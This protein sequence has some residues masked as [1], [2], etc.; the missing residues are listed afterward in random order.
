MNK[1]PLVSI[2]IT[3]YNRS[4]WLQRAIESALAQDYSEFEVIISDNCSTDNSD[5]VIRRYTNDS[6]IKYSRNDTNIGMNANFQKALNILANGEY[7]VFLCSDDYFINNS[8]VSQAA[9]M[10]FSNPGVSIVWGRNVGVF[11]DN[12]LKSH[13]LMPN[14]N[15]AIH[16]K[17][18]DIILDFM[19][20]PFWL[21]YGAYMTK[22]KLINNF[23][24]IV[25]DIP[26]NLELLLEGDAMFIEKDSYVYR[27][28][29]NNAAM[30][31]SF[32][33]IILQ[34]R[35]ILQVLDTAEMKFPTKEKSLVNSK[36]TVIIETAKSLLTL[37]AYRNIGGYRKVYSY[38]EKE[39]PHLV[40]QLPTKKR[41]I[42]LK[43]FVIQIILSSRILCKIASFIFPQKRIF[44]IKYDN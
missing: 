21:G 2:I 40:S 30:N 18:I 14:L 32:E 6:R 4:R 17:G 7:I 33:L 13:Y 22:S 24:I 10:L 3:S 31:Y 20:K 1:S 37:Y 23:E 29:N 16:R 39:F 8:F 38:F 44:R 11:E 9:E 25:D 15:N 36:N 19:F 41:S 28:H 34:M 27:R 12:G 42:E 35:K 43:Y 26:T 5:E